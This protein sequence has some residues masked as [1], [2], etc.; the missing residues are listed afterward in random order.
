VKASDKPIALPMPSITLFRDESW[1]RL[2]E[3]A[4]NG[5]VNRAIEG[6]LRFPAGF[7]DAVR[8][9]ERQKLVAA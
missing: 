5:F 6:G 1:S 3:R 2:S 4:L 8:Q 9:A 7:I